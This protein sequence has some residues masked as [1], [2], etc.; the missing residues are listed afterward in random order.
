MTSHY[1]ARALPPRAR[2]RPDEGDLAR[3]ARRIDSALL[4]CWLAAAW[5]TIG[6]WMISLALAARSPLEVLFAALR[7]K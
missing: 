2:S 4:L 3:R 7:G 1:R 5:G 6:Y